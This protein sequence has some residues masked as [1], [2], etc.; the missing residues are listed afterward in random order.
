MGTMPSVKMEIPESQVVKWVLEL[1]PG[2]KQAVLRL[3]IPQ[4]DEMEALITRGNQRI[5]EICRARGR[6]WDDLSEVER[7]QMVDDLL[8]EA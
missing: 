8:H 1:S 6:N 5:R 3:L 4:V 2:A 7:E